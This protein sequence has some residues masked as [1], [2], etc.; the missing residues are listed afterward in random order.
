M[1]WFSEAAN[2]GSFRCEEEI[3]GSIGSISMNEKCEKDGALRP[4]WPQ[5]MT[6]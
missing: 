6:V 4:L 1:F 2:V 5:D 3:V